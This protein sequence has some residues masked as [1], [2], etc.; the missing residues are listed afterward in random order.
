[1]ALTSFGTRFQ[2]LDLSL[3]TRFQGL[4]FAMLFQGLELGLGLTGLGGRLLLALTLLA[5]GLLAL[6]GFIFR[7]DELKGSHWDLGG[8]QHSPALARS[9]RDAGSASPRTSKDPNSGSPRSSKDSSSD[10]GSRALAAC[11]FLPLPFL[12]F[13]FLDLSLAG[14]R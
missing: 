3:S 9:S 8:K 14:V 7:R 13:F 6:L 11:F 1:M 12:P 5:F 4:K 10:S 2:G